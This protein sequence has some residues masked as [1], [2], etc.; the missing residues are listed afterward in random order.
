MSKRKLPSIQKVTVN[1]AYAFQAPLTALDRWN[2]ALR[3]TEAF[4]GNVIEILD[5]IGEDFFTGDG[6]TAKRVNDK[7]KNMTGPVTVLINSPGGIVEEGLTI[8]ELLREYP[9]T[10][11]VKVLGMAASIASIVAMAGD[12]IEVAKAGFFMVHNAAT[13]AVGTRFEMAK[14]FDWLEM[15]DEQMRDVYAARSGLSA[16]K[17]ASMMDRETFMK[18][19]DAVKNGFADAFLPSDQVSEWATAIVQRKSAVNRIEA[20]MARAGCTS[21]QRRKLFAE[22]KTGMPGAADDAKP[23]AGVS[24]DLRASLAKIDIT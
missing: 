4:S 24:E 5:I 6:V 7:L 9:D 1:E 19:A 21:A 11:N 13:I 17:I 15:V 14:A 20:L 2:A 18:G 10:V 22:L 23:G 8:F 12:S 16:D 3:P